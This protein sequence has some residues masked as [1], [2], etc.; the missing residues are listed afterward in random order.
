MH[1]E[2]EKKKVWP[3]ATR[4]KKNRELISITMKA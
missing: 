4:R 2:G 1:E 3:A